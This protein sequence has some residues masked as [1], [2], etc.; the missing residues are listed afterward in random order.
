MNPW[1]PWPIGEVV[2]TGHL[3][4]EQAACHVSIAKK[5]D[6]RRSWLMSSVVRVA[7]SV[8]TGFY[9]QQ[10]SVLTKHRGEKT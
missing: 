7:R 9:V 3:R 10:S 4:C 1:R 5:Y 6:I 2:L 8:T